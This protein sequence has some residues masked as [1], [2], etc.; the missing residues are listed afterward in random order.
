VR[1][2]SSCSVYVPQASLEEAQ[3]I[4][5]G[6]QQ[7]SMGAGWAPPGGTPQLSTV[8]EG[9]GARVSYCIDEG[10][11]AEVI[12]DLENLDKLIRVV[13]QVVDEVVQVAKDVG[14]FVEAVAKKLWPF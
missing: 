3:N 8:P 12:K 6:H 14:N 9:E 7:A 1:V 2:S 4:I 5:R 13:V 11:A 10:Q